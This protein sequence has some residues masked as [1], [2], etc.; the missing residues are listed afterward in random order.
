[1]V[2][3]MTGRL[4]GFNQWGCNYALNYTCNSPRTETW[5]PSHILQVLRATLIQGRS[6]SEVIQ[7]ASPYLIIACEKGST[8]H[9]LEW[10]KREQDANGDQNV[11]KWEVFKAR[12]M[13]TFPMV[14]LV[15]CQRRMLARKVLFQEIVVVSTVTTHFWGC[16]FSIQ[17]L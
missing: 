15:Y 17:I 10:K 14:V 6:V 13:I 11:S 4:G 5:Q 3:G 12:S 16:T 1:M 7:L 2:V 8:V 9:G